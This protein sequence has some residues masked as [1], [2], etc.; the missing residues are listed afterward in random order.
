[1]TLARKSANNIKSLCLRE[2]M[3]IDSVVVEAAIMRWIAGACS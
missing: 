1:M 3:V 2:Q